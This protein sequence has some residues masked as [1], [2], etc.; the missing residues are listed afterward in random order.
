MHR[1]IKTGLISFGIVALAAG[2]FLGG[3]RYGVTSTLQAVDWANEKCFTL[4]QSE[5][6]D[7]LTQDALL[8]I[9]SVRILKDVDPDSPYYDELYQVLQSFAERVGEEMK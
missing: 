5:E 3:F 8:L 1:K 9:R 6:S 7:F 2:S 4:L